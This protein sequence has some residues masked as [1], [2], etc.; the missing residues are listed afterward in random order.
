MLWFLHLQDVHIEGLHGNSIDMDSAT[1]ILIL[2]VLHEGGERGAPWDEGG[3]HLSEVQ[4]QQ[5]S[6]CVWVQYF[7]EIHLVT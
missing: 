3:L 7:H 5:S 2:D 4:L 6:N 1:Y